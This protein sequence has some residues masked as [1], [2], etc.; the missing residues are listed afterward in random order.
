MRTLPELLNSWLPATDRPSILIAAGDTA[1]FLPHV[2]KLQQADNHFEV[3]RVNAPADAQRLV[4]RGSIAILLVD[5]ENQ[6]PG[7]LELLL[8]AVSKDKPPQI[9]VASTKSQAK[10][11]PRPIAAVDSY[12]DA[13]SWLHL[14]QDCAKRFQAGKLSDLLAGDLFETLG[15]MPD[16]G[17]LRVCS[18]D[19]FGD[20]CVSQGKAVY[21]E[22]GRQSGEE[23]AA[24]MCD[25]KECLFE[26]RVLPEFLRQNMDKPLA[27]VR[28][29]SAAAPAVR[30]KEADFEEPD[31][32]PVLEEMLRT[33]PAKETPAEMHEPGMEEPDD[34][35]TFDPKAAETD[36]MVEEP[37]EFFL[38]DVDSPSG[39][40]ALEALEESLEACE[41]PSSMDFDSAPAPDPV[42]QP[43]VA[44]A[45]PPLPRVF[46]SLAIVC[47]NRMVSCDPATDA[48]YFDPE[49][50]SVFY[51]RSKAYVMRH[52]LG[53]SPVLQ[54]GGGDATILV[55]AAA[56]GDC[57]IAART[58]SRQI[59]AEQ[60]QELDRLVQLHGS[61]T[62]AFSR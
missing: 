11:A 25:W 41:E 51:E 58:T 29:S 56:G 13:V 24:K 22:V 5:A 4:R 35:P 57:L 37:Q 43:Q 7:N 26:Y 3:V 15:A 47:M 18:G 12:L 1:P 20:I 55:V 62:P 33:A 42:E 59:S 16:E 38:R 44:P 17:W 27:E 8:E 46:D 48:R 60:Q 9:L 54:I 30:P 2:E 52:Q 49:T 14:I 40:E 39:L 61:P 19:E 28:R 50:L 53:E 34:L 32:F 23:A 6:L 31:Q 10:T 45:P 36:I 21:C